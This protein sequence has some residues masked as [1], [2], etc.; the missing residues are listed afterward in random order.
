MHR[1]HPEVDYFHVYSFNS[2]YLLKNGMVRFLS[3][4]TIV[5][6]NV[7]EHQQKLLP[8]IAY[9]IAAINH[10]YVPSMSFFLS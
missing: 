5:P 2:F 6:C 1:Y 8:I 4:Y 3:I 10:C 9:V 7:V